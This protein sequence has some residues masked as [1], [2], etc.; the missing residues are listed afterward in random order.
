MLVMPSILAPWLM[1]WSGWF[2]R[3]YLVRCR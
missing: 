2:A 1:P 3:L